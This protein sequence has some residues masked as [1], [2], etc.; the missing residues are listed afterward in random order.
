MMS[1]TLQEAVLDV[2]K[3]VEYIKKD[4][5]NAQ[6]GYKFTSAEAIVGEVRAAAIKHCVLISIEY[7]EA[8]DLD[9]G[10]T[11]N[12]TA[13]YRVRVKGR[14][15]LQKGAEV[16]SFDFYGEG[17][18]SGDKAMP[19]AQTM[20]LKQA[21]RQI[22]LIE[23]GEADADRETV[24]EQVAKAPL[25]QRTKKLPPEIVAHFRALRLTTKQVETILDANNDDAE[26]LRGWVADHP[27]PKTGMPAQGEE[28]MP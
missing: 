26:A 8:T 13:I 9:A 21:L 16:M 2:M 10:H 7:S 23:T 19:K 4:G 5:T 20:C 14:L 28:G 6:Q 27:L 3:D 24:P 12:G 11:K 15:T 17:A 22:F 1:K 25:A 18:D